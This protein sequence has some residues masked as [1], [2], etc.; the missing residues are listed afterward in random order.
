MT[1]KILADGCG[2]IEATGRAGCAAGT[3]ADFGCTS[4][5]PKPQSA[6]LSVSKQRRRSNGRAAE[7]NMAGY[8]WAPGGAVEPKAEGGAP[9]RTQ[10]LGGLLSGRKATVSGLRLVSTGKP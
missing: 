9:G 5:H 10:M 3:L 2:T 8:S 1:G 4:V 7:G 6:K